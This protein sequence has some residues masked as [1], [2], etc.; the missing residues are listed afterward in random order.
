MVESSLPSAV[1]RMQSEPA[2]EKIDHTMIQ[3]VPTEFRRI[4]SENPD[5]VQPNQ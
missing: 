2:D 3:D 5:N 4:Q 1:Q